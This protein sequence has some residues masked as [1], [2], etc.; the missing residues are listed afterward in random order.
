MFLRD[1]YIQGSGLWE[2]MIFEYER[3]AFS[4]RKSIFFPSLDIESIYGINEGVFFKRL[5]GR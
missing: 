1:Q 4:T 5:P 3:A 2:F